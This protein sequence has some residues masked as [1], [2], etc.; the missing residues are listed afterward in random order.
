MLNENI[1]FKCDDKLNEGFEELMKNHI[2][3][4]HKSI[5]LTK[6]HRDKGDIYCPFEVGYINKNHEI[7]KDCPYKLEHLLKENNNAQ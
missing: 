4:Y 3:E 1:C 2:E 5:V 7:P 6:K